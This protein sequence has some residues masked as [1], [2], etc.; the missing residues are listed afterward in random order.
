MGEVLDG[1]RPRTSSKSA[2]TQRLG[3]V[4]TRCAPITVT[5]GKLEKP[6]PSYIPLEAGLSDG[7]DSFRR[8][9]TYSPPAPPR[10]RAPA[11]RLP[12]T[13]AVPWNSGRCVSPGIRCVLFVVVA[14]VPSFSVDRRIK[15]QE[16]LNGAYG[17]A[18]YCLS[19]FVASFPYI[20][21]SAFVYQTIFHWLVRALPR[22]LGILR[23][24]AGGA[25]GLR[26]RTGF[27]P[28][29]LDGVYGV[30]YRRNRGPRNRRNLAGESRGRAQRNIAVGFTRE[31]DH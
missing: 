5:T 10:P 20:I 9:L 11:P 16:M 22:T 13:R 1:D 14:A 3:W 4:S 27:V 25:A 23:A 26:H 18:L 28:D 2:R 31:P 12:L 24:R 30:W 17:P 29:V 19:Q 7:V 21:F 15:L 8:L 6:R